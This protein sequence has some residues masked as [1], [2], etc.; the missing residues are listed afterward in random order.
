MLTE[1]R[2]PKV[3]VSLALVTRA[4]Q[5]FCRANGRDETTPAVVPLKPHRDARK[6]GV[7]RLD[8]VGEAGAAV[9]A[10][11]CLRATAEVE[12]SIYNDLLPR[13]SVAALRYYGTLEGPTDPYRW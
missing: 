13:M 1:N 11:R 7:Y 10:K 9:V 2:P 5:D 8:G 3:D 12:H 6:S 4:W